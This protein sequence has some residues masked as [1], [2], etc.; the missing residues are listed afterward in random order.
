MSRA[1]AARKLGWPVGTVNWR[2]ARARTLLAQALSRR[3]VILSGGVLAAAL[4]ELPARAALGSTLVRTTVDAGMLLKTGG[5]VAM[6]PVSDKVLS[7]TEGVVKAMLLSKLKVP[8]IVLCFLASFST[9][10]GMVSYGAAPD[11]RKITQS[12]DS[13]SQTDAGFVAGKN[14]IVQAPTEKL[15]IEVNWIAERYRKS[16]AIEWF[17]W[18]QSRWPN[19]CLIKAGKLQDQ[20]S[21][22]TVLQFANDGLL[23]SAE[24]AVQGSPDSIL[25]ES[26]PH[27]ICHVLF[28]H[29]FRRPLPRWA[30]EGAAILSGSA[31][32]KAKYEESLREVLKTPG[33]FISLERLLEFKEYPNDVMA[34]YA[35][36]YSLT[37]FLIETKDRESYLKFLSD[38]M[39]DG[40]E[41]AT[42]RHY[43]FNSVA[44]LEAAWLRW[45]EKQS[46]ASVQPGHNDAKT[47]SKLARQRQDSHAPATTKRQLPVD[48]DLRP[49]PKDG[50]SHLNYTVAFQVGGTKPTELDQSPTPRLILNDGTQVRVVLE[51][52]G[53]VS[54]LARTLDRRFPALVVDLRLWPQE[55]NRVLLHLDFQENDTQKSIHYLSRGDVKEPSTQIRSVG[56]SLITSQM[57]ELGKKTRI[58]LAEASDGPERWVDFTVT[59]GEPGSKRTAK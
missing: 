17:G 58:V 9:C 7:L 50:K 46:T 40:W 8:A 45:V 42:P 43:P 21:G 1:E 26:L 57:L 16:L 10:V 47:G 56:H 23:K 22:A 49:H 41:Q 53:W 4:S 3:G 48:L 52:T 6:L 18:E 54:D 51:E 55:E 5:S 29:H 25:S 28:A 2:L 19:P 14:F 35:E 12:N 39:R 33:R 30:D 34:L 59:K 36:G 11:T 20:P 15:A 27:E 37:R 32:E 13:S 44:E 24:M 38:G 31:E